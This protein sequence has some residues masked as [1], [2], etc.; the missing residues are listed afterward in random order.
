M[1]DP[2]AGMIH[3]LRGTRPWVRLASI[4]GFV[5]AAVMGFLGFDATVRG[6]TSVRFQG[7]PFFLLYFVFSVGFLILSLYL[8]RYASRIS[9]FL[10]QGHSVQ[11][12]G[13]LE[14]Q[15]KFW[16]FTGL[17]ALLSLVLLLL[18]AGFSLL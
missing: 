15:R 7:G 8:H 13:A 6:L 18:A 16:K 17:F 2:N 9:V 5:L 10:A 4:I 11:L 12:E 14:A 3:V 1:I